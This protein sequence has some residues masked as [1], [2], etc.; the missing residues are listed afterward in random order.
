VSHGP[1]RGELIGAF[2]D[3]GVGGEIQEIQL[4]AKVW[5]AGQRG[6]E[7]GNV[8]S[9]NVYGNDPGTRL[10]ECLGDRPADAT[11]RP[12]N[13]NTATGQAGIISPRH[14]LSSTSNSVSVHG[15]NGP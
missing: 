2:E 8:R 6:R 7:N 1:K 13:H 5:A 3:C 9:G 10:S 11:S 4:K 12:R 15:Q 14:I